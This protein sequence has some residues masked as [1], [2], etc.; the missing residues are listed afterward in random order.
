M[1]SGKVKK[2]ANKIVV[3]PE[4]VAN[5]PS[6]RSAPRSKTPI[7]PSQSQILEVSDG[8][9]EGVTLIQVNELGE[10]VGDPSILGM[11]YG[12]T[13]PKD[14]KLHQLLSIFIID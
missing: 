14:E 12:E 13:I 2:L 7:A 3:T 11:C 6:R 9:A 1:S 8:S 5:S 10:V 4:E